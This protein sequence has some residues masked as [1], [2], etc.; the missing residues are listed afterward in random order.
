MNEII[1]TETPQPAG[2]SA[3]ETTLN[4]TIAKT[5]EISDLDFDMSEEPQDVP[6]K[7][8]RRVRI[9]MSVI[10][11]LV[12]FVG[13]GVFASFFLRYYLADRAADRGNYAK[14]YEAFT[15]LNNFL[16]SPERAAEQY[17]LMRYAQ[18]E[19]LCQQEDFLNAYQMFRALGDFQDAAQRAETALLMQDAVNHYVE[20]MELY[21]KDDFDSLVRSYG[22]F[23]GIK[24]ENFRDTAERMESLL[25]KLDDLAVGYADQGYCF[26]VPEILDFLAE[27]GYPRAEEL[28]AEIVAQEHI[29][30][31]GSYY[32]MD[33]SHIGSFS[34]STTREDFFTLW[35]YMYLTSTTKLHVPAARGGAA[36]S[37]YVDQVLERVEQGYYLSEIVLPEYPSIYDWYSEV[38]WD[39]G[40]MMDYMNVYT[41]WGSGY[42]ASELAAHVEALDNF[43]RES[44][45]VLN[46]NLLLGAS[47]SNRQKAQV[48]YDWVCFYLTYDHTTEIHDAGIAVE[49]RLGVC[50]S[51]VAIYARMC[52]L[53]GVPTYGQSG[54][55]NDQADGETHIWTVQE[56]ENGDLF[57]TDPTWGDTYDFWTDAYELSGDD[58]YQAFHTDYADRIWSS[59][60]YFWQSKLFYSHTPHFEFPHEWV[61]SVTSR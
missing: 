42:T 26:R 51:Y 30:P 48:I 32:D 36:S 28:R 46:E 47:M 50:E 53:V 4:E 29:E 60:T 10:V 23:E 52:N 55:T 43:C 31:D 21:G 49:G 8:R 35:R 27:K 19:E 41:K 45:R 22:G 16:D 54:K 15:A 7:K 44:I 6:P 1:E 38:Y 37:S 25:V 56:D 59:G 34:G 58:L 9:V 33:T 39:D 24:V 18:A 57:Y 40:Y 11:C 20:A 13:I 14:A 61:K 5:M 3:E 12:F 17:D 2:Q